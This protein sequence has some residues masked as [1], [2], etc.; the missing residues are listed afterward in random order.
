MLQR[1]LLAW[2]ILSSTISYVWP[3]LRGWFAGIPD[4]FVATNAGMISWLIGITMF[5]IGMMLPRDEVRQAIQRWPAVL[6]GTVVQFGT[7]PLLAFS[8]GKLMGLSGDAF[9]G[10]ILVGCVPGAMASN[11]LTMNARGNISYSVSLTTTATLLSPLAVPLLLGLV[12]PTS[13][14]VSL[15]MTAVSIKLFLTVVGPVVAGHM[16]SRVM[17]NWEHR[18]ARYG[19]VVANLAILWIIAVVVGQN[20]DRIGQVQLPML[21]ALLLVNVGGFAAGLLGGRAMQLPIPMRRALT[22]EVGMQNA[23]LGTWLAMSLFPN[24]TV[25]IA[26]AIYT[27][28]CMLT[29]TLLAN[30]WSRIT[31]APRIADIAEGAPEDDRAT[32]VSPT[33]D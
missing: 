19:G 16:L 27:F 21:T 23:G 15:S 12:L 10:L 14:P 26:P 4:P 29:G 17:P 20:R 7:M 3:L 18:A 5:A 9:V 33:D 32:S 8:I 30:V 13:T 11:V 1:Y 2:L 22:L 6:G 25:A 28:G 31:V 24:T